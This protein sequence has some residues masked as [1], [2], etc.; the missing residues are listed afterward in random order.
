MLHYFR[1][2]LL[3]ETLLKDIVSIFLL[4]LVLIVPS[5]LDARQAST[6]DEL[7][8]MYSITAC[9][10]CH[11]DKYE[12]WKTSSMG[13]SVI[14][15]RVLR[16]WRT[17]IRLAVDQEASLARKD[18][19]IC[20]NC[21][22]PHIKDATDSLV[23]HIAELVL[24]AVEDKSDSNRESAKQ[25]LSK[26]NINCL[27]C[28]NLKST[29]FDHAP[30]EKTIYTPDKVDSSTHAEM[31]F[32]TVQTDFISTSDFCAQCHHCPPNVPWEEC[33]TL[34]ST[35]IDDFVH[36]GR[37]ETCQSCHMMGE[38]RVHKFLGPNNSDFLK[39]AV[40]LEVNARATRYLDTY[41]DKK[42]PAVVVEVR[43][44][45]N[46]GHTIPHG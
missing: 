14:D 21:H 37:S 46:A 12:E 26:L 4:V 3:M 38:K 25:E 5:A 39:S 30:Q 1:V 8:E 27:D 22:V 16:G 40:T 18:L 6:I 2:S 42:M 24:T 43:L 44:T 35:Y 29:G 10:E 36:S 11:Q 32:D 7:A 33:T 13:N 41:E 15:P 19:R 20:L 31:G 17:F 9:A 45:N 28:H 34:Y 23:E